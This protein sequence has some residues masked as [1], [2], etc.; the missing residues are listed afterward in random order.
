MSQTLCYWVIAGNTVI[1]VIIFFMMWGDRNGHRRILKVPDTAQQ[2]SGT[3][4]QSTAE[5]AYEADG[6]EQSSP[7]QV[8]KILR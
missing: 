2:T 8:D 3:C 4:S 6:G 1:C 7:E 5:A